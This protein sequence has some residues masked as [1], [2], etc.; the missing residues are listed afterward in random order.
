M[1]TFLSNFFHRRTNDK[2]DG[3][4]ISLPRPPFRQLLKSPR[5]R[6]SF[7]CFP[8]VVLP[9]AS[10]DGLKNLLSQ[11][12]FEE[13]RLEHQEMSL[14]EL[15]CILQCGYGVLDRRTK[16]RPLPSLS[17]HYPL[18]IYVFLF[19]PLDAC[20]PGLYWYD[21]SQHRLEP[22]SL[23]LFSLYERQMFAPAEWPLSARI[24][25]CLTI[26]FPSA[27]EDY[28]SRGYRYALFEAGHLAQNMLLAGLSMKKRLIPLEG[29]REEEIERTLGVNMSEERVLSAWCL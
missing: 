25:I 26:F 13:S 4:A 16:Q 2:T 5:A 15:A 24:L 10:G 17:L 11:N 9:E 3:G 18:G 8:A 6:H 23:K 20:A 22:V 29:V 14:R 1:A 12:Q 19:E 7:D 27:T 21:V 28:G